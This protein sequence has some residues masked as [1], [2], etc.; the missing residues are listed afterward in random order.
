MTN[1]MQNRLCHN[2]L[3]LHPCNKLNY[4]P[5]QGKVEMFLQNLGLF[6]PKRPM[7]Y[8]RGSTKDQSRNQLYE[9]VS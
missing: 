7:P 3:N 6:F 9:D 8:Q 4:Q 5:I 2:S 1:I